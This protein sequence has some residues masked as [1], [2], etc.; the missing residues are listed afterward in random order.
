MTQIKSY[1][2][3]KHDKY[4]FYLKYAFSIGSIVM[5]TLQELRSK[6]TEE[7]RWIPSQGILDRKWKK[8]TIPCFGLGAQITPLIYFENKG[9]CF[10]F[11]ILAPAGG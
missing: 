2:I 9:G 4:F 10:F 8:G 7:G 6:S 5:N 11:L 1:T 3:L